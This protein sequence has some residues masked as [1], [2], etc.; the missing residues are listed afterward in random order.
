[1]T[2]IEF[3]LRSITVIHDFTVVVPGKVVRYKPGV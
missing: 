1:M 3:F 2:S